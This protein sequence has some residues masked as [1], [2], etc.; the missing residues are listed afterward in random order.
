MLLGVGTGSTA[1][2]FIAEIGAS[3]IPLAGAVPSSLATGRLLAREG[4]AVVEPAGVS[5][6]ELY[7]DGADEADTE[8]RLIKGG[9]GALTREKMLASIAQMFICITDD[10]K[11]SMQLGTF[12]LAVEVLPCAV[13]A[14]KRGLVELGGVPGLRSG[15]ITD[16]GNV[17]L[18]V[19]G[20]DFA[21]PVRLE[22]M[23]DGIAGV[24]ANGVFAR[25]PADLLIVGTSE[26]GTRRLVRA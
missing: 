3:G 17:V 14:A 6:L 22:S 4:I 9:G 10:S 1:A 8:L 23:I 13:A 11:E 7:V 15:F 18:D 25:R 16:N 20:L 12:P 5:H 24:V 21:D 26:G 19:I 2:A